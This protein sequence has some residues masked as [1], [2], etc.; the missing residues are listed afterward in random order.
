MGLKAIMYEAIG[1]KLHE[2]FFVGVNSGG[3]S[4]WLM[5]D[6]GEEVMMLNAYQ[7][8]SAIYEDVRLLCIKNE[9]V[10]SMTMA[11]L[12]G[13]VLQS[14]GPDIRKL[15]SNSVKKLE[16]WGVKWFHDTLEMEVS[17]SEYFDKE[18]QHNRYQFLLT[19]VG[20]GFI[21]EA[22][23]FSTIDDLIDYVR[24][25]FE[26]LEI[27]AG[28]SVPKKYLAAYDEKLL[29]MVSQKDREMFIIK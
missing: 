26:V 1:G 16:R 21:S 6:Q 13:A 24:Q 25:Y 28:I 5:A 8:T 20:S 29:A 15:L 27:N 10:N 2:C 23:D 19:C 4:Q 17:I 18:A 12:L 11:H 3:E 7:R 22:D 14:Y 9:M